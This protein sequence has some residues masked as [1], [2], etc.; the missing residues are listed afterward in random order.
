[1]SDPMIAAVVQM[2][3]GPDV[4]ENLARASALVRRA[5]SRGARLIVLPENVAYFGDEAGKLAV[6]ERFNPDELPAGLIGLTACAL[7]RETR[8]TLV[9]GGV[10]ELTDAPSARTH[11]TAVVISPAGDI[12]ARY[13]KVHL[14]DVDLPDGSVYRESTAVAPGREVVVTDTPAGVLGLSVC[15]DVRFPELYRAL[16]KAGATILAVPAAF[17]VPTGRD[18]WHVLLRARAV[19]TQ[20]FV[21]AAAQWGTHPNGRQ[22]YGHAL[23]VDPWGTVL[24]ECADGE[25]VALAELDPARVRSVRASLP[26]H[27]HHVLDAK[28]LDL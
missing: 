22:T 5:A 9:W 3:S 24:A 15:Y 18:H 21:L 20:C 14:F 1:M 2:T 8:A 26:C 23:I 27:A 7:A 12:A 11:N 6:A 13:R 17:T 19:E 28:E 10:P 4:R 16:A 25:G